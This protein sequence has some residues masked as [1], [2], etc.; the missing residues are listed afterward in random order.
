MGK[1]DPVSGPA[2]PGSLRVFIGYDPR[3]PIAYNVLQHSIVRHASRPVSITPLILRQLPLKRRGL[4][5]FTYSR[6]LVPWLCGY[7]GQALFLDADMVVKGDIAEVFADFDGEVAMQVSQAQFEWASAMLFNCD[8][9]GHLTPEFVEDKSNVLFDM[10][11]AERIG[12]LSPT[13]NHCVGY[14]EPQDSKLYHYTQGIPVWEQTRGV[15]DLPFM[16]EAKAMLHTVSWQELMGN[17]VHAE[18]VRKRLDLARI[19]G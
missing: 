4:T 1:D 7:S 16:T 14:A 10:K 18:H 5:E 3:Q 2:Y 8:R 15:E 17:S 13:W 9:C 19:Q 6:F 12:Q 11:W